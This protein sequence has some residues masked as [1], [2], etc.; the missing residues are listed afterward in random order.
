MEE[1]RTDF[2]CLRR[3]QG[4]IATYA[5]RV[6]TCYTVA[7]GRY[8]RALELA[9]APELSGSTMI[10]PSTSSSSSLSKESLSSVP[11]LPLSSLPSSSVPMSSPPESEAELPSEVLLVTYGLSFRGLERFIFHS[12]CFF[13]FSSSSNNISP[14]LFGSIGGRCRKLVICSCSSMPIESLRN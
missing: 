9:D 14:H 8:Y 7:K 1:I 13:S 12:C 6:I 11:P 5:S 4:Y 3:N 10:G 2:L